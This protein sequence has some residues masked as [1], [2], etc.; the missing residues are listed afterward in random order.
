MT[1]LQILQSTLSL[2]DFEISLFVEENMTELIHFIELDK[3]DLMEMG[4][5]RGPA[6]AIVAYIKTL[7]PE[8]PKDV[9]SVKF[10]TESRDS[11]FEK[12]VIAYNS[13]KDVISDL[14]SFTDRVVRIEGKI[15]FTKTQEML[16]FKGNPG[17]LW[18]GN[19][20]VL[21]DNLDDSEIWLHPRTS[22][23]LQDGIDSMGIEWI[24]L[25]EEGMCL[26]AFAE[27][28]GLLR[29]KDDETVFEKFSDINS[30]LL[31]TTKATLQA[32][33][34]KLSD[35]IRYVKIFVK[36][37][38]NKSADQKNKKHLV[39][40]S[41]SNA[42]LS[43]LLL[44]MFSSDELRRFCRYNIDDEFVS[45]ISFSGSDAGIAFNVAD[46]LKRQGFVNQPGLW[47]NLVKERPRR[48]H[49]IY[50]VA[51]SFGLNL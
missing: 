21:V 26:V 25:C 10:E 37:L 50:A 27:R 14:K 29:N 36:D 13:G 19:P 2:S 1:F 43:A 38:N 48:E 44:N 3:K 4:F 46:A 9:L 24:K 40:S 51:R 28:K 12:I 41:N 35:Y 20:I 5:K 6:N 8:K 31:K 22:E 49:E 23:H 33:G 34:E 47:I 15:D 18:K 16:A 39:I 7:V 32:S 17:S 45:S 30:S 42:N 11:Q